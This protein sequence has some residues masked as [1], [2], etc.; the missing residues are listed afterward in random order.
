MRIV[1]C[2]DAHADA[3]TLGAPRFDDVAHALRSAAAAAVSSSDDDPTAPPPVDAFVFLGDLADPDQ[4]GHTL[5]AAA[6]A[7]E[8]ANQL[9][10]EGVPSYWVAGNHDWS[11]D[12]SG[13]TTL[14]P[15]AALARSDPKIHVA[16]RSRWFEL[17]S[18]S[19]RPRSTSAASILCV[20]YVPP[21]V[22]DV[23]P[24]SLVA[25]VTD[26]AR[27]PFLLA[28][29]LSLRGMVPG[30][31]GEEMARGTEV[32]L[33]DESFARVPWRVCLNGH[34]HRQQTHV[35]PSGLSV[36]IPGA[37]ARFRFDEEQNRPG[38]LV[39]EF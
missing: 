2:S 16:E 20:P 37:L 23:D 8:V 12:G 15:L 11:H 30:E 27:G 25:G 14:L 33:P 36:L 31:E 26:A 3:H 19:Q 10:A 18:R 38:Y 32:F 21:Q 34:Y 6:L 35:C 39:V 24:A 5:R 29:H 22:G 28:S 17:R 1:V 13:A 9:S 4:G 7:V